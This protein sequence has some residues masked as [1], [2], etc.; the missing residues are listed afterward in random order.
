M[1]DPKDRQHRDVSTARQ[2]HANGESEPKNPSR[3]DAIRYLIGGAVAAACPIPSH[4]F[5]ATAQAATAAPHSGSSAGAAAASTPAQLGSESN[6]ICHRVRDGEEFKLPDPSKEYEVIIV[7]GGPSG[8][9]TAYKLRESNFLLLEKEPRFGGNAIS[10]QWKDQWYSTGAAYQ[11]DDGVEALCREIGMPIYRIRSVD[12][13]IIN[14]K[15]VPNFWT[16]GLWKSSYPDAVKKN[17]DKFFRDMKAIDLEANKEKLDNMSFAELLKPYGP[18]LIAWFDNFGPNNWGAKAADTSAYIGADSVNWGGGVE[19][20]RYTWPGGLG[21]ISLAL[22][23]KMLKLAPERM[24]NKAIVLQVE[25]KASKVHVSYMENGEIMTAAA[26]AVVVACP[27]FIGKKIVK[28]LP[29]A[30]YEAMDELRYQPYLVVN[31]CSNQVIYNGSYD[32]NIPAPSPIVDFNVA[33]W[34]INR[35]NKEVNRPAVLTCYVPR[36]ER[37]RSK[38]LHDDY[39]MQLGQQVVEKVETWF[40]G[41]KSKIEEVHIYRR[42][43]PMYVSAPGVM[44]R[45]APE[46]RKPLGNIFFAH[47][48]TEGGI[49]EYSTGLRAAERVTKEVTTALGKQAARANIAVPSV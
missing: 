11:M 13:A 26:K 45:V 19:P 7:G 20:E 10:E 12:A 4:L 29:K 24:H 49:S 15:L 28:G 30:Q 48:D 21:R 46:V 14:D 31:V 32:T 3:R 18:E 36:P 27:K 8:L 34:V 17:F 33:D 41:A 2:D 42:G 5:A 22:S 43:H 35:D 6:D 44:T 1:T 40:P 9:M 16:G 37:E 38:I 39:C 25:Q 47:S 23:E